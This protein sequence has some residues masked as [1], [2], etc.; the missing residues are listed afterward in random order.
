MLA[1][2]L[3]LVA[4]EPRVSNAFVLLV[5]RA[6]GS[7]NCQSLPAHDDDGGMR[8]TC[9][10][11]PFMIP[12]KKQKKQN[13]VRLYGILDDYDASSSSSS[14]DD[15]SQQQQETNAEYE[16]LFDDLVFCTGDVKAVIANRLQAC[17]E[18]GFRQF[19]QNS[20][21][22]ADNPEESQALQELVDTIAV[23]Q[24]DVQ[25][26]TL[27]AE[28][29]A[30]AAA[31]AAQE[32]RAQIDADAQAQQAPDVTSPLSAADILK[33]AQAIDQEIITA[34]SAEAAETEQLP[35]DFMRDAKAVRG[36]AG[37]NQKG[38]MRVGGS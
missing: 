11:I 29:A 35:D 3:L 13:F 12:T 6:D 9:S 33:K 21:D 38:N 2:F 19:L 24:A 28:Q 15:S 18:P 23:V 14:P 34:S 7:R 25:A 4:T 1:L 36:L 37:F 8:T 5:S 30:N 20:Q 17:T 26:A 22:R 31:Q 10:A 27:A 16:R 32:R